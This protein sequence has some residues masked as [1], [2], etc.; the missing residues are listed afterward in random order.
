MWFDRVLFGRHP[1][2][3]CCNTK[4]V[5]HNWVEYLHKKN[6]SPDAHSLSRKTE[7]GEEMKKEAETGKE[8]RGV[9]KKERER[10]STILISIRNYYLSFI[11]GEPSRVFIL[12]LGVLKH[13]SAVWLVVDISLW[14]KKKNIFFF[15]LG[16]VESFRFLP[17][18]Y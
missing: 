16:L 3:H 10:F 8:P 6:L 13:M 15:V 12:V 7:R 9:K 4:S 14:K 18:R 2:T 11:T 5:F 1:C 17:L